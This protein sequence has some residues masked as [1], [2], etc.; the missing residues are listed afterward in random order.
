MK[1][2]DYLH[3]NESKVQGV[4]SALSQLLADFQV[5]YANLHGFHW[6]VKGKGFFQLHAKYEELYDDAAEKIDE[7]AERI[8][9]LGATP[10]NRYSIAVQRSQIAEDGFEPSGHKG[11]EKVLDSLSVLIKTER[12]T[13]KLADEAD[14]EVTQA[15]MSDYLKGQEKTVWMLTAFLAERQRA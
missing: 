4:V 14:D 12:E 1:T 2:L 7:L 13:L 11:L 15:L 10:E 6:N 5:F 3:L 8:L 9:Q